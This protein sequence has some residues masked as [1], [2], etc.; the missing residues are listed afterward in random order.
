MLSS[1]RI[2]IVRIGAIRRA[3]QSCDADK[4]EGVGPSI[5]DIVGH[6]PGRVH[7]AVSAACPLF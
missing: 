6:V 7:L 4:V 1:F 3:I 2:A 5:D